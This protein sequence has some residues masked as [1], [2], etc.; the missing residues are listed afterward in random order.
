MLA[1]VLLQKMRTGAEGTLPVRGVHGHDPHIEGSASEQ[2]E[3]GPLEISDILDLFGSDRS[4]VICGAIVFGSR[5]VQPLAVD[6]FVFSGP[7]VG[8]SPVSEL[9]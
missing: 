7:L 8:S 2:I 1:L 5:I 6:F 4:L 3:G 9:N